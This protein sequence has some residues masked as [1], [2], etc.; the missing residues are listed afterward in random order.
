VGN[1]VPV[2]LVQIPFAVVFRAF[3]GVVQKLANVHTLINSE[4]LRLHLTRLGVTSM[5]V[6]L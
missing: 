1:I 3:W 4:G 2:I 6:S 5:H